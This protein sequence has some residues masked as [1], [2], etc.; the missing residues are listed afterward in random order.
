MQK[1]IRNIVIGL[2]AALGTSFAVADSAPKSASNVTNA[3]E[4]AHVASAPA[5]A[6]Q[7]FSTAEWRYVGGEPGWIHEVGN[8]GSQAGKSR[9]EVRNELVE[10]QLNPGAQVRHLSLY[11]R[12]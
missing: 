1:Q 7:S 12:G 4:H 10:F 2:V 8:R 9:A 5:K 3:A 11:I 6:E